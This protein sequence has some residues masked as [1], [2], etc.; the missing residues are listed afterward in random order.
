[1][2]VIEADAARKFT[3]SPPAQ[4]VNL[5]RARSVMSE[6]RLDALVGTTDEN[7]YYL[8]GHAPDSV[9]AHFWDTWAA[10]ILPREQDAAPCLVI[11]E[12]DL[13]YCVT[14]PTWMPEVRTYGAGWSSAASLLDKINE[15]IGVDTDI[16]ESLRQ[17]YRQTQQDKSPSLVDAIAHYIDNELSSGPMRVGFDDLRVAAAVAERLG[18]RLETVDG[19]QPLRKI[20]LVK[21]P[22]EIDLL[23][24]AAQINDEALHETAAAVSEGRPWYDMVRA[25]RE[26]LVKRDAKPMGERGMLFSAGPD[27]GF[28]LDHGYVERKRFAN[29]DAVVLDAICTYR[30]YHADMARTATVG[31]PSKRHLE[32]HEA[33]KTALEIAEDRLRP[34]VRTV[35]VVEAAA[36]VL[37][38][39]GLDPDAMTLVFH[40]IGLNIFDYASP[41]DGFVGWVV[42]SDTV[43]NFEVF[44]RDPDYGGMHLEDSVLVK[45]RGLDHF[46]TFPREIVTAAN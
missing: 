26:G 2:G 24:K 39:H 15:G 13:A 14:H 20:R 8:S 19:L 18:N 27:G 21:T 36:D 43:M 28:V 5:E 44:N 45:D 9:L 4:F 1:M 40:P 10:A 35:D 3:P 25:Y 22:P 6:L 11:S 12:Y 32:L 38:K 30:M 7:L 34:G 42:E 46:S 31:E 37:R 23:R 16:R 29:G 33:V 17:L 41:E